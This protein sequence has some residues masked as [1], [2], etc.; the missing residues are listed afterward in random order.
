MGVDRIDRA[1]GIP[2]KLRAFAAA[3]ARYPELQERATLV[4]FAIPSR[5][6]LP[7]HTALR[8]EIER[9]AG[10]I[11]G[12]FGRPGWVPVHYLHREP[13]ADE[14]LAYYRAAD[15]ALVTPLKAG[16]HLM[17]KE[18]CAA[19]LEGRGVLVLSEFAGAAPQLAAGALMVNPFDTQAVARTLRRA[20]KMKSR[21]R[22]TRMRR[23]REAVRTR[24]VFW[25]AESCLA[26][27]SAGRLD[28]HLDE[29]TAAKTHFGI[30]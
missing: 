29:K 19:N 11:N 7:R 15:V 17:A 22:G 10:E 23:L 16:M 3:L 28:G 27:A 21:E 5:E 1:H 25:W 30:Q 8:G 20:L 12:A 26:A 4:Q 13:E 14:L 24:D 18:Y 9:L 6:I 2:E